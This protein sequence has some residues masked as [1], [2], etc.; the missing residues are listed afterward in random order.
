VK[1]RRVG[2]EK[3]RSRAGRTIWARE[4]MLDRPSPSSSLAE[5]RRS[6]FFFFWRGAVL[7]S[8]FRRGRSKID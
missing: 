3:A 5:S 7:W 4:N 8:L 1:R 6:L 2:V